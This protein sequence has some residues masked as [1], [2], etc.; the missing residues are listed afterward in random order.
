MPKEI[1]NESLRYHAKEASSRRIWGKS[2]ADK[3]D[4]YWLQSDQV[5][6]SDFDAKCN[7]ISTGR[8]F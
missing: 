6:L 7:P 4:N 1:V 8:K 5:E 2:W 3:Y